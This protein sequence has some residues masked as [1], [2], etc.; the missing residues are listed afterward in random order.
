MK[1]PRM[2]ELQNSF[3]GGMGKDLQGKKDSK[4]NK[5]PEAH[6]VE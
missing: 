5:A 3:A 2:E 6:P 1:I 4:K